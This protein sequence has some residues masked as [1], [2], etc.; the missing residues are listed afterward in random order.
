MARHFNGLPKAV[1][2]E[3]I[4]VVVDRLSKV[5]YFI[6][7]KNPYTSIDVAQAFMNTIQGTW[8]A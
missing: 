4:V 6:P 2:K 1:G 7:L 8:H 5:A 3:V